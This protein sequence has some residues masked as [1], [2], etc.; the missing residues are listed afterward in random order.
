MQGKSL[1][2][3]AAR[4]MRGGGFDRG[5]S[6]EPRA[7]GSSGSGGAEARAWSWRASSRSCERAAA[8]S[9]GLR[10]GGSLVEVLQREG[11]DG[12]V[13]VCAV[14]ACVRI[15]GIEES[16]F[17]YLRGVRSVVLSRKRRGRG[18]SLD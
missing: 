18:E 14:R 6:V 5:C 15:V 3:R 13:L 11:G 10:R 12:D 16:V 9:L 1:R 7:A 8:G 17:R 2:W 4:V